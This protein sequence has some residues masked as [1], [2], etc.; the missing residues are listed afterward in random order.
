MTL[1]RFG[2]CLLLVST[3][4]WAQETPPP[5]DAQA[6]FEQGPAASTPSAPALYVEEPVQAT[7]GRISARAQ[8][9]LSAGD[10]DPQAGLLLQ[11][12]RTQMAVIS[13]RDINRIHCP[14]AI[15][16]VFFSQEKPVEVSPSSNDVF[17]KLKHRVQGE[18]D[19]PVTT[20]IDLHVVCGEDVYTMILQPQDVP[21]VTLRLGNPLRDRAA[22]VARDWGA[23]P[24]EDK[25]Q[26]LT[27]MVYRDEVPPTF[28]RTSVL[29]E[30]RF[31]R[32]WKNLQIRAVQRVTAPGLGLAAVEFE[33]R[34]IDGG[35]SLDERDFL[36]PDISNQLVSVTVDPLVLSNRGEVAR[37]I[38]VERS[39][40]DGHH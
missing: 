6:F 7:R 14:S 21:S 24:I 32:L 13:N 29:D 10:D 1:R 36:S 33:L 27:R 38:I 18:R 25:V 12:E 31:P 19:T 34:S 37:L 30:R 11:P 17:V 16:D 20:P 8:A 9:D 22:S 35:I 4:G 15:G 23:L 26:K 40:T 39:T 5:Q 28:Q 3:A 2:C